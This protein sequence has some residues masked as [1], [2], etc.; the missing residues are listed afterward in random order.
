MSTVTVD[1]RPSQAANRTR[2]LA[3]FFVLCVQTAFFAVLV[4]RPLTVEADNGRQEQAGWKIVTSH[5]P[6]LWGS[7]RARRCFPSVL[8][9]GWLLA[10][11]VT[12]ARQDSR[13][14]P[15]RVAIA[16]TWQPA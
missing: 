1:L 13:F 3:L 12:R 6:K 7:M 15:P 8:Y 2:W 5:A 9:P 16:V 4:K 14:H 10:L 11:G